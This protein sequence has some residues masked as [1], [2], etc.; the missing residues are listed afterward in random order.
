MLNKT[1]SPDLHSWVSSAN[2]EG[3]DFPIQN[4]PFGVFRR[5]DN[6][7]LSTGIAIGT[8]I[9]DIT[10][11]AECGMWNSH[12]QS[13]LE[14][15]KDGKL[16]YL[17]GTSPTEVSKLR[18]V[19]SSALEQ[20]SSQENKLK[21]CLVAQ[22]AVDMMLPC[23]IG[24]YTDFYAGI[25]HARSV[26]KLFRPERP[27]LDNYKSLPVGYHGRASSIQVSEN[28]VKRPSGQIKNINEDPVFCPTKKL[29]YELEVGAFV[30]YGNIQGEPISINDAE[31][32][33]FG[34]VL[35]N[36]WSAR[37][38]Q[39]W[40]YQPLGPFLAKNFSTTI[41]PW[42]VTMDALAPFRSVHI[43][44]AEDPPI[45]SYLDS[46]ANRRSG[47]FDIVLEV[48]IETRKMREQGIAPQWISRSNFKESYWTVAQ[49]LTH[50]TSNGCN[51]RV[52]DLMGSGTQSGE[53]KEEAGSLLE[54]TENGTKPLTL[55]S[56]EA[57]VFLEDGDRVILQAFCVRPGF[58]RIGFGACVGIVLG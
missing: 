15:A 12:T 10:C 29:D 33:V 30:G 35:L 51:V 3:T 40:E 52:G 49:M 21:D 8:Q 58:R 18:E 19:L 38:I 24:D 46:E 2:D 37:D 45:L 32:S 34:L 13:L 50:H 4:L 14:N 28:I 6:G 39:A 25:H 5:Q 53:K 7:R 54:L 20:G 48:N 47:G 26:G 16:V 23:H 57:R 43:R 27:L 44:P 22:D 1:H 36:D 11:A 31:R 55:S 56:G 9:L 17:M 41:S 42:I